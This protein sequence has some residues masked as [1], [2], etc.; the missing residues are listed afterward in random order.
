M[1]EH[2]REAEGAEPGAEAPEAKGEEAGDELDPGLFG[3]LPRSRPGARSP[4]RRRSGA[5]SAA[6]ADPTGA[7]SRTRPPSPASSAARASAGGGRRASASPPRSGER[8]PAAPT[9]SGEGGGIEDLAWAGIAVTA[10]A[11]TLGV[12]LLSRAID[13]ARRATERR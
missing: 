9:E 11:A 10:E 12:R 7:R 13:A 6:S 8:E 5:A 2:P 3:K 4:R 1:T